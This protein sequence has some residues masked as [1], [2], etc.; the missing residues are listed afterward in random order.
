VS[1]VSGGTLQ[2]N[3]L[4]ASGTFQ[5]QT[6]NQPSGPWTTVTLPLTSDGTNV[7]CAVSTTNLQQYFRL[8]GQ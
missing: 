1:K 6:A 2:F 8:T 7:S 5:V 4:L 3:W